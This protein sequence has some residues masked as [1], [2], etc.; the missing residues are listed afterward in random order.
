MK[1]QKPG[2][3]VGSWGK[4][5]IVP[6]TG[7]SWACLGVAS[8]FWGCQGVL[9]PVSCRDIQGGHDF[10]LQLL[11]WGGAGTRKWRDMPGLQA[12]W[13]HASC[14]RVVSDP[15]LRLK[16][17]G[18]S[19]HQEWKRPVN[20]YIFISNACSFAFS[21]SKRRDMLPCMPWTSEELVRGEKV[22]WVSLLLIQVY[23]GFTHLVLLLKGEVY[24]LFKEI[25]KTDL[26]RG[27]L[28]QTR[29]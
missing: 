26:W 6:S 8:L 9:L 27:E 25:E 15:E 5:R 11:S 1:C 22:K 21:C 24:R 13:Q 28:K 3:S 29:K 12:L 10:L 23:H 7:E 19:L 16:C 17:V 20:T 4:V 18:P 2:A 14:L